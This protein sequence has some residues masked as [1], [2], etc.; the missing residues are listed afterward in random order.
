MRVIIQDKLSALRSGKLKVCVQSTV[1]RER[2]IFSFFSP[3]K[4]RRHN[5]LNATR[6]VFRK[7]NTEKEGIDINF[8]ENART[9]DT[10]FSC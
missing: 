6:A 10:F 4:G 7:K 1:K 8:F 3:K 2:E 9:S 5:S